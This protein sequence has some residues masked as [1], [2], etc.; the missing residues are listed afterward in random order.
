MY[1]RLEM[2]KQHSIASGRK[3]RS[4]ADAYKEFRAAFPEG[5]TGARPEYL[6]RLRD[7]GKGR[8]VAL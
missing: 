5:Q 8:N 6:R 3:Q 4:F 7:R 1:T 2:V